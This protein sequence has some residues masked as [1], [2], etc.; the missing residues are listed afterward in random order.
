MVGNGAVFFFCRWISNFPS[1][2]IEKTILSS[3]CVLGTLTKDQLTVCAGFWAPSSVPL[4][5][6]SVFMPIPYCF[7]CCSSV[8]YFK[9]K[10]YDASILFSCLLF[11][12]FCQCFQ[13]TKQIYKLWCESQFFTSRVPGFAHLLFLRILTHHPI[14]PFH[15]HLWAG[16]C[17]KVLERWQQKEQIIFSAYVMLIF[18]WTGETR[19]KQIW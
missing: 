11:N 7:D 9:T 17:S 3:Y 8:T 12:E 13:I 4:V 10:T 15:R 6:M 2:I 16:H 14:Q 1:T 5:Y 18:C 19:V